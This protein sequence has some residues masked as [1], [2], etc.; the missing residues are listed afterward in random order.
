MKLNLIL[1]FTLGL[2]LQGL[3]ET[4]NLKITYKG[5][6]IKAH[7]VSAFIGSSFLGSGV[8]NDNG[9]V[10]ISVSSLPVKDINLKGE[11]VCGNAKKSWSIDGYV[12]LDGNNFFHLKMEE[13]MKEIIEAS[14]GFMSEKMIAASYGLVCSGGSS[15][16]SNESTSSGGTD[17]ALSLPTLPVRSKAEILQSDKNVLETKIASI[18]RKI[19]KK[20]KSIRDGDVIGSKKNDA[21]YDVKE[22]KIDKQLVQNDLDK[23]NLTIA[24]GRLR[25]D[26]RTMFKDR[27]AELEENLDSVKS[28]HKKGVSLLSA[29]EKDAD[30]VIA[31]EKMGSMSTLDLK[32]KKISLKSTLGKKKLKLKAKAKFMSPNDISALEKQISLIETSIN[33]IDEELNLRTEEKE[34]EE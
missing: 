2:V 13:P 29:S 33:A 14:G 7:T 21:L 30:L 32:R 4:I 28:D 5:S 27:K 20:N 16:G 19:E 18:D 31:K 15:S 23:V 22:L 26:E 11:K 17:G 6:G 25:K 12:R 8:T 3:S 1:L 10:S 34:T 24:N 9:E